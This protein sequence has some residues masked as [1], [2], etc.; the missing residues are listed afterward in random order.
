[1]P[2]HLKKASRW[3]AFSV[4]AGRSATARDGAGKRSADISP[5]N[6]EFS[7]HPR[8]VKLVREWLRG[9][10]IL[11]AGRYS[12]WEYYNCDAFIAGRKAAD[13]VKELLEKRSAARPQAAEQVGA[14]A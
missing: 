10:N 1:M 8:N 6:A 9:Q 14:G 12:E 3:R 4:R 5:F 2:A 7:K 13:T 11:L